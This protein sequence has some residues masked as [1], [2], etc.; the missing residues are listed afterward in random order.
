MRK[1]DDIHHIVIGILSGIVV[2]QQPAV[3]RHGLPLLNS[4]KR[5]DE[6][7]EK[8]I[9]RPRQSAN[10][11]TKKCHYL[12]LKLMHEKKTRNSHSSHT[13]TSLKIPCFSTFTLPVE[14]TTTT[15][16]EKVGGGLN[17]SDFFLLLLLMGSRVKIWILRRLTF[18]ALLLPE[19]T[20]FIY[21]FLLPHHAV[22]PSVDMLHERQHRWVEQKLSLA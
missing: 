6:C 3:I 2:R 9:N 20:I 1:I 22:H 5:N 7:R 17:F 16:A 19:R 8:A 11:R 4:D 10:R 15:T 13:V 18:P 21:V 12:E 14:T